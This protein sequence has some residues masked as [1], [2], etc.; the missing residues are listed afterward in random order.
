MKDEYF[1]T[2]RKLKKDRI[3][4]F[5][6]ILS[7][8][9][10]IASILNAFLF[11][12]VN[13]IEHILLILIGLLAGTIANLL[14]LKSSILKEENQMDITAQRAARVIMSEMNSKDSNLITETGIVC[15]YPSL[16]IDL[17]QEKMAQCKSGEIY[18]MKIFIPDIESVIETFR[19]CIDQ[20]QRNVKVLLWN[21]SCIE[22]LD[23]RGIGINMSGKLQTENIERNIELLQ[24]LKAELKNPNKLNVK[25][26][27]EFISL[28]V[29][30]YG[31]D[32]I[33]GFYLPGRLATNGM[34]LKLSR[35][36]SIYQEFK[37]SFDKNWLNGKPAF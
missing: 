28:S 20:N 24:K 5:V 11:E 2:L 37:Q 32:L 27:N 30:G 19:T 9:T 15:T 33:A 26:H 12:N 35:G 1:D 10:V 29:L 18:L 13:I 34:Q 14:V 6:I 31:D 25:I 3:K 21:P 22:P 36:G 4:L 7:L 23:R 17:Q 8:L 16:H